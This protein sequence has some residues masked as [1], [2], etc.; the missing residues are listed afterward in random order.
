MQRKT[1][2]PLFD[3]LSSLYTAIVD[4][5]DNRVTALLLLQLRSW[6]TNICKFDPRSGHELPQGLDQL[7]QK[8]ATENSPNKNIIQDRLYRILEHVND[9]LHTT[10]DN[11]NHKI[12]REH[13]MV[14]IYAA[15]EV[16]S[17]SNQW[18]SKQTGRN[19]REKLA[20]KPYI[21][22]VRRRSS[23][24]TTENKLLKAFVIKLEDK[25]YNQESLFKALNVEYNDRLL[26]GLQRWLRQEEAIDIGLW[27][28]IPPNNTL[29]QDRRYRKIW[30]SW[31]WLQRLD[32]DI[33]CDSNRLSS[34][35]LTAIYW[36]M[37]SVLKQSNQVRLIQQP[38][39][40]DYD[41]C[42]VSAFE[43]VIE[44][45][46]Y[47][48]QDIAVCNGMIRNI[49]ADKPFGFIRTKDKMDYFFHANDLM[50]GLDFDSLKVKTAVSFVMGENNQGK[51][52]KEIRLY[53]EVRPKKLT[54][55]LSDDKIQITVEAE[56][57]FTLEK[58][59]VE[60]AIQLNPADLSHFISQ[61]SNTLLNTLK[62]KK[63]KIKVSKVTKTEAKNIV[64]G[65]CSTRPI[66]TTDSDPTN[67]QHLPSR[68]LLQRWRNESTD[69]IDIDCS[70][71]TAIKLAPAILSTSMYDLFSEDVTENNQNKEFRVHAAMF[72]SNQI[73][74]YIKTEKLTY[75]VPDAINDFSLETIRKS[76]NFYYKS[77]TPLPRSIA[78][79][80]DWQS[81]NDFKQ[82]SIKQGDI[83]TVLDIN[84]VGY[85]FT[86]VVCKYDRNLESQLPQSRGFYWERHPTVVMNDNNITHELLRS[87]ESTGCSSSREL[88]DLFGVDGLVN[89]A[90]QLSF[91][92]ENSNWYDLPNSFSNYL[93]NNS[94]INNEILNVFQKNAPS[95]EKFS[96][97]N[98]LF[99]LPLS[100]GIKKTHNNKSIRWLPSSKDLTKGGLT[101]ADWQAKVEDTPLWR[102]HLPEL[103]IQ[104]VRDGVSEKFFLVK[105]V[106]VTPMR[107]KVVGVPVKESF[108]LPSDQARYSFPLNIGEGDH[109]S[110]NVAELRSP[111][112]PLISDTECRLKMT[113]TYGADE[114][115]ELR[116]IPLDIE[117]AGFK[118]VKAN[119]GSV[120]EL[121]VDLNSLPIPSFPE[122]K[123]WADFQRFPKEN[124][125]EFSDLLDWVK[126]DIDKIVDIR[127]FFQ[128]SASKRQYNNDVADYWNWKEDKNGN[129]FCYLKY[130]SGD[131]FFHE[132]NFEKFTPE[133]EKISFDKEKQKDRDGY[134]AR[135]ITIGRTI[136]KKTIDQ[137]KRSLRFPVLTIW[138]NGH[139]LSEYEVPDHFRN[140][141]SEGTGTA[142][143]I[144]ESEN[145]PNSLKEELFF[146]LSCL[147]KD[148]PLEISQ[149][150]LEHSKDKNQLRKYQRNIA[151]AIGTAELE[152]QQELLL[153]M[154]HPVDNEGLTRSITL[155]I[156]AVAFWR[157]EE[158][159]NKL[160]EQNINDLIVN[161]LS[162][163]KFDLEKVAG[164][165]GAY[166]I[167]TLCKHLELL[168]ALLRTRNFESES[169]K[170]LLAPS[171]PV[172]K[173]YTHLIDEVIK[174][175][176]EK[177]IKLTSRIE[178]EIDKPEHLHKTPDL[179]YAL[180]M[181]L[182]GDSGANAIVIKGISDDHMNLNK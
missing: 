58:T 43:Q 107:G 33:Q 54:S 71:S 40:C 117:E 127:L 23:S 68:L 26:L 125:T 22:A 137:L 78:A 139:S 144:M 95:I 70:T 138:N 153:N 94:V 92:D 148:T 164:G 99:L 69:S 147:H 5:T 171:N 120:A 44:G 129:K 93:A 12:L 166:Q 84:K 2:K 19:L 36:S 175:L 132:S 39:L 102:D 165:G 97:S 62:I 157:V 42:Q 25:L 169:I 47:P 156:L 6:L 113:Y 11:L 16:D 173:K 163:L 80:F 57:P 100:Q 72:F 174:L 161:L 27:N 180:N 133:A 178:L 63:K 31:L 77:A 154:L 66:F 123:S 59:D 81:S 83:V 152:W 162:C 3:T 121:P 104:A 126:R 167:S 88:I 146:F 53:K 49:V 159:I 177:H 24:D 37:I 141:V 86:P 1:T 115:Y 110:H 98:S 181:Y 29:L 13:A 76:I 55:S 41:E 149:T 143:T 9:A 109:S 15:R 182:T 67:A 17:V 10:L 114:P 142:L 18:L 48:E 155:E 176:Q 130:D 145:I 158:L 4:E 89:E 52:A 30:D 128:G 87:I 179:L 106:T 135:N 124:G 96:D 108:T 51:C 90:G 103:S 170:A 101:L 111:A 91:N 8:L 35:L 32:D 172:T 140:T 151:F 75:L 46:L 50:V 116:F 136:H 134:V 45:Y 150:L 61:T 119:W 85:S 73:H 118:S 160:S 168:L 28:N 7:L 64:I 38:V 105:D 65:L 112:F 74:Q 20:G 34:D 131:V 21:K 60:L 82:S 122:R 79:I 56:K 14:P